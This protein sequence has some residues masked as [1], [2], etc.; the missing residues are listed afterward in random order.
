MKF[1][2]N[3]YKAKK[4]KS[5]RRKWKIVAVVAI[6]LFFFLPILQPTPAFAE[7]TLT[8]E[9]IENEIK[10]SINDQLGDLDFGSLEDI[11]NSLTQGQGDIFGGKSFLEKIK[12]IITGE[13]ADGST[14]IWGA[15]LSLFFDNLLKFLPIISAVIAIAIFGG[16]LQGLR[17]NTNAKSISNMIHFVTY[18]MIVVILL[19][20]VVN[21]VQMTSGVISNLKAQMDAIFPI[22]LTLLTAVG[23]TVSVSVYQPAMALLTGTIM[24]LFT[25]ILLPIFIFSTIFSVVSN[26]SNTVKLDKFTSFFNSSYKWLVGLI[27][28]VFSAFLSIQGIA[29]GSV[30][31]V[32]IRTAKYAIKSYV[33]ILGSYLS[34]GL[35]IIL[36]STNLI[37]NAVGAAGLILLVATI[38][39]P[40]I[41]LIMFMLALK[42]IAGIVE[43]LGNKQVADF[44]AGLSKSMVLLISLIIG[45]AF[46]YFITLGLVMCSANI[47]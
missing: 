4:P 1:R 41:E 42:L 8:Q 38:I 35:S 32:S 43:P 47:V 24:N 17:P 26:L 10:D 2:A 6:A 22:L 19:T 7:G 40:L 28:T 37:K 15:L 14:S 27:F 34:D 46:I 31:G 11:I 13:F 33:P 23:G 45:V 20:V 25:Y 44:I 12:S 30:D 36:A 5:K 3:I 21:M 16:M 18:G 9:E 39:S 29:A